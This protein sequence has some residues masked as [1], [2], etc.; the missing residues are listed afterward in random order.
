MASNG[1]FTDMG[2]FVDSEGEGD[3]DECDGDMNHSVRSLSKSPVKMNK[4]IC[5][6][7]NLMMKNSKMTLSYQ[8]NLS[9]VVEE[10]SMGS[11]MVSV[12]QKFLSPDLLIQK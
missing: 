6:P 10:N 3:V 7:R 4:E 1:G 11:G 8:R 9:D 5:K 2:S 12:D